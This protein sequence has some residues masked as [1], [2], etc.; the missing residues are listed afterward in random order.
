MAALMRP[1]PREVLYAV[2]TLLLLFAFAIV[3]MAIA[4]F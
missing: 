3:L 4:K 1:P 2:D